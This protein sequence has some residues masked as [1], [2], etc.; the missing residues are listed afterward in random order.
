VS[1][2]S[3]GWNGPSSARASSRV[4]PSTYSKTRWAMGWS[5]GGSGSRRIPGWATDPAT[6]ASW[7]RAATARPVAPPGRGTFT[8]TGHQRPRSQASQ[9]SQR[10]PS[11]SSA[12]AS[13]SGASSWPGGQFHDGSGSI[14]EAPYDGAGGGGPRRPPPPEGGAPGA[15][16]GAGGG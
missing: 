12:Q 16:G 8:T 10:R 15:G 6:C 5:R 11:P 13:S 14:D 7:A 9:V 4:G 1:S 3:A 2:T